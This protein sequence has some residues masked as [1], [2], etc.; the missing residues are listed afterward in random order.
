[1]TL[2]DW[3]A[4]ESG[5]MTLMAAHFSVNKTAVWSWKV[6]GVPASRMKAVRD[7]TQGQVTLEDMVPDAESVKNAEPNQGH[8]AGRPVIDVARPVAVAQEGA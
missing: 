7:F 1:M 6:H 4:E 8:P 3:L 5:R 2:S